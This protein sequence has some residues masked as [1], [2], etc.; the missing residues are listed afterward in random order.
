MIMSQCLEQKKMLEMFLENYWLIMNDREITVIKIENIG[1]EKI[2]NRIYCGKRVSG[3]G[4]L[5]K[6]WWNNIELSITGMRKNQKKKNKMAGTPD[7]DGGW[8]DCKVDV[9]EKNIRK[10]K[11]TSY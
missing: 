9:D 4:R 6:S 10:K 7:E 2:L 1:S 3:W 8:E 5:T 11:K